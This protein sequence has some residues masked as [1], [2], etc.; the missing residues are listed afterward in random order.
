VKLS[1][2]K[3]LSS[4]SFFLWL[5]L[6]GFVF[7]YVAVLQCAGSYFDGIAGLLERR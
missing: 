2:A 5:K 6:F 7:G 1:V 3:T 4:G